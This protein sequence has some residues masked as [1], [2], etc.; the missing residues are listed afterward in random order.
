[1]LQ[2]QQKKCF[3]YILLFPVVFP[4]F[5]ANKH[6]KC[7]NRAWQRGELQQIS[8]WTYPVFLNLSKSAAIKH[9]FEFISEVRLI[10]KSF[11]NLLLIALFR[12]KNLTH[13]LSKTNTFADI[14]HWFSFSHTGRLP[15][16]LI[17]KYI[18]PILLISLFVLSSFVFSSSSS[19][20]GWWCKCFV[21]K[22]FERD[23]FFMIGATQIKMLFSLS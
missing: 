11:K 9:T 14:T 16:E 23:F 17:L 4:N 21:V 19:F 7:K 5:A 18:N 13:A 22:H 10:F 20:Y 3:N 2:L 15:A 12:I 6:S 1:M 8:P